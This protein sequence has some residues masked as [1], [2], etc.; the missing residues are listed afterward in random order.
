MPLVPIA[1]SVCVDGV[2]E[3]RCNIKALMNNFSQSAE[4]LVLD[5][6]KLDDFLSDYLRNHSTRDSVG[7]N[8]NLNRLLSTVTRIISRPLKFS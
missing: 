3:T 1:W 2:L 5:L 4:Y 6:H 7:I 8:R